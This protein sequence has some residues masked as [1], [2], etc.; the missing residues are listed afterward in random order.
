MLAVATIASSGLAAGVGVA[1][2]VSP[3]FAGS[4]GE[5]GLFDQF[6]EYPDTGDESLGFSCMYEGPAGAVVGQEIAF[7]SVCKTALGLGTSTPKPAAVMTSFTHSVPDGFEFV[8]AQVT[9]YDWDEP[10]YVIK[11]L[12]SSVAVDP[13]SGDVTL[14]APAEGW[15]IPEGFNGKA[16]YYSGDVTF[17][18]RYKPTVPVLDGVSHVKYTG[19]YDGVTIPA[20]TDR[21]FSTGNTGVAELP[22]TGSSGS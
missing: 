1:G 15:T 18:L 8:G 7:K 19:I 17:I 12:P 20:T 21:W 14:T 5:P 11:V 13:T 16:T 22:G 9:S 2:A 3:L 10:P 6:R 4:S